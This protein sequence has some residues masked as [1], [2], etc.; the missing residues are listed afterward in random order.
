MVIRVVGVL[1]VFTNVGLLIY[2]R[3]AITTNQSIIFFSCVFI[4]L[5]I[6]YLLSFRKMEEDEVGR[7]C[8]LKTE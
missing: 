6:K 1:G 2:V 5:L 8:K 3:N 4:I 7:R